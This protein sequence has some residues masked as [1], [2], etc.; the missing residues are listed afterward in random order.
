MALRRRLIERGGDGRTLDPAVV[1]HKWELFLE[2]MRY[3]EGGSCRHDAVLRYFGDEEETLAGCGNCDVCLRLE[4]GNQGPDPEVVSTAVRKALSAV[5]R[6]HGRFGLGAA[7]KLLRGSPDPR[8]A[9]AGLDRT[10]THGTLSE[11]SEEWLLRL[12]RRCVTAGWADFQG[13][14]RPVIVLTEAG[15]TVMRG[16][17]P[18]KLLLPPA[19]V[20]PSPTARAPR[21]GP[22]HRAEAEPAP[23]LLDAEGRALFEALRRHRLALAR[24]EGVPPYVVASDRTLREIAQLRPRNLQELQLAHGI[25]PARLEKYGAGLLAVVSSGNSSAG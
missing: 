5:A 1:R 11:H 21:R 9:R 6:I 13:R 25:G 18:A 16:D 17:R 19:A 7:A 20:L 23:E 3:A 2:L 14:D 10:P 24:S 15:R 4:V 12:L 8:L 22:G